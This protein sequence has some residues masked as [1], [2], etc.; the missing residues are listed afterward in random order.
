MT[1]AQ[2][3]LLVQIIITLTGSGVLVA[4]INAVSSRRR[5]RAESAKTYAEGGGAV[6]SA[7]K[8]LGD[9]AVALLVPLREEQAR[10]AADNQDLRRQISDLRQEVRAGQ[11]REMD[12]EERESLALTHIR[13][14][15]EW[16]RVA[17]EKLSAAGIPIDPP[18]T[19]PR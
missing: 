13:A 18:P 17:A 4:A 12:A 10:L 15:T 3:G 6:A 19:T 11:R 9:T 7:A 14:Y 1:G 5:T 16:A 8:E 2:N